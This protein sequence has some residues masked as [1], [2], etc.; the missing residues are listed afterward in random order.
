MTKIA[1]L[2]STHNRLNLTKETLRNIFLFAGI[3]FT[4]FW[5]DDNSTDETKEFLESLNPSN[6]CTNIVKYKYFDNKGKSVRLNNILRDIYTKDYD[7]FCVID[8]D[9]LLPLNWLKD[10]VS[11]LQED[12]SVGICGVLVEPNLIKDNSKC[13]GFAPK[14]IITSLMGGACMVWGNSIKTKIGVFCED[15]GFY[16]HEDADFTYRCRLVGL[17][18]VFL[19]NMGIHLG[20]ENLDDAYK[21]KKMQNFHKS[22]NLLYNNIEKYCNN[23]KTILIK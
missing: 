9:L 17:T 23:T 5:A 15:Y 3:D 8:N 21:A 13:F 14:Y 11:I 16:G 19:H 18:T 6:Y 10:C 1:V 12:N 20:I 22:K 2:L 4:L 7:Y